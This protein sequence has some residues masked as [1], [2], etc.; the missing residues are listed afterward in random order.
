MRFFRCLP[1]R[2]RLG[3]LALGMVLVTGSCGEPEVTV[4]GI[5]GGWTTAGCEFSRT[6]ETEVIGGR[7]W[8]VTP[9]ALE[10]AIGR[11][12]KGG[13]TE[14]P[15]SYAGIEVDQQRVRAVVFRVPSAP[16]DEFIRNAAQDTCVF[17]RDAPYGL[18][19]LTGWHDRVLADL[20]AWK[21]RGV[22]IAT[23]S[24][25]HD[26]AGV[27][28]GTPDVDRARDALPRQYGRRAPLIVIEEG[29]VHP[30][31]GT[32]IPTVPPPGG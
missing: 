16:F 10:A 8:P 13:R 24:A 9:T 2:C 3:C 22:L 1:S 6:P 7:T 5:I 25:R 11:I 28:I 17:V 32:G 19:E 21:A 4:P 23:I 26:G 20:A 18:T 14:H 15:A 31:P 30:L 12:D 29:P 27:E